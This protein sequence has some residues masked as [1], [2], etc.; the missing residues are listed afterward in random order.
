MA[1]RVRLHSPSHPDLLLHRASELR[2][3]R[4]LCDVL[5]RVGQQD[6]PAHSLVLACA[7]RTLARL[8]LPQGPR[9]LCNLDFLAPAT[10]KHALDFAYT[11]SLEVA[12]EEL[13]SLL[14]TARDLEMEELEQ[15]CLRALGTGGPDGTGIGD[16]AGGHDS[17]GIGDRT[18]GYDGVAIGDKPGGHG[19]V[20]DRTGGHD[21]VAIGDRTGGHDGVAIGDRAD[22]PDEVG[23]GNRTSGHD[24]VGIGDWAGGHDRVAI[25]DRAGGHDG[26][27][28]GDRAGSHD[29]VGAQDARKETADGMSQ[30]KSPGNH[31]LVLLADGPCLAL[32][33]PDSKG[34]QIQDGSLAP[35][36]V[37]FEQSSLKPRESVITATARPLP[38]EHRAHP[39]PPEALWGPEGV[40]SGYQPCPPLL[41]YQLQSLP[42]P[43]GNLGPGHMALSASVGFHGYVR[44]FPCGLEMGKPGSPSGITGREKQLEDQRL[45]AVPAK[46]SGYDLCSQ[47]GP[48]AQHLPLLCHPRPQSLPLPRFRAQR[49]C[50]KD[51]P[52]LST[53]PPGEPATAASTTLYLMY[54]PRCPPRALPAGAWSYICQLCQRRFPSQTALRRHSRSHMG[55]RLLER[56]FCARGFQAEAG[57][58]GPRRA[59][60]GEKPYECGE[61]S[62]RFTLKHQMETHYRVHTGEKPFQ[63]KLCPQRSRDYSAMIKH[64]RTHGGAAPYRCTLCRQFCPSLAAMQ[65]HMKGHCPEEL[66]SDWTIETTY[67]YSS[68][69]SS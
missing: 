12:P 59:S 58:R 30:M 14:A 6:F 19:G 65:K 16:R 28:I 31:D 55:Q 36:W 42:S 52:P 67:L 27:V 64:L 63:C 9:K 38:Q 45:L 4:A 3:V 56:E 35:S 68:S 53:A 39:W 33:R 40:V 29:G 69:T 44:P 57:L 66:P 24:G 43:L 20:G 32:G 54:G 15:V 47:R 5:V 37:L 10:F 62:K 51:L 25:D 61:C 60:P 17:V 21:G 2:H 23:I 1:R 49:S 8:L 50:D 18:G 13:A 48:D 11:G 26:V 22:G 34:S 7:S 41:S 46:Y